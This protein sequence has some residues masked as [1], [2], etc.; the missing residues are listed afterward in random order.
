MDYKRVVDQQ[1][2]T[3]K[4]FEDAYKQIAEES[5]D[6]QTALGNLI[7][8]ALTLRAQKESYEIVEEAVRATIKEI[9]ID[10][11]RIDSHA[12]NAGEAIIVAASEYPD[13]DNKA[14]ETLVIAD[15]ELAER[16]TP[17]RKVR[18]RKPS[19]RITPN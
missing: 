9:M 5:T 14:L 1:V 17:F 11:L 16:L 2:Q 10:E 12:T 15:K 6:A 3:I 4:E 19:L 18:T 7:D 8:L 13:Y